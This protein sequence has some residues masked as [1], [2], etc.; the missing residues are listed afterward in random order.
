MV[1]NMHA[2]ENTECLRI[3]DPA[4]IRNLSTF[5]LVKLNQ[6]MMGP[7]KYVNHL[8]SERLYILLRLKLVVH[9]VRIFHQLRYLLLKKM[10]ELKLE[11]GKLLQM[12]REIYSCNFSLNSFALVM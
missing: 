8:Q 12:L 1:I 4:V 3:L 6:E 5:L 2:S 9:L 11:I 7:E 10:Q